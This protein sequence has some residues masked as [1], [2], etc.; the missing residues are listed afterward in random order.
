ML[1]VNAMVNNSGSDSTGKEFTK[2]I[3][4]YK[5]MVIC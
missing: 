5:N 1:C 3:G 4:L 2:W